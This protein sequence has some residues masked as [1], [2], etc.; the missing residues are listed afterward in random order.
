MKLQR[1]I[2]KAVIWKMICIITCLPVTYL[3][4][5]NWITSLWLTLTLEVISFV[6]YIIYEQ[7][8]K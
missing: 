4:T 2:L 7:I 3:F 8:F 1:I 6:E 5:G